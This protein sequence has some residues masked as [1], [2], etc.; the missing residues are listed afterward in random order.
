MSI[1]YA[2]RYIEVIVV[3]CELLFIQTHVICVYVSSLCNGFAAKREV[4]FCVKLAA[5]ARVIALNLLLF[6]AVWLAVCVSC[7]RYSHLEWCDL[8]LSICYAERYI[9]VVIVV[10][11]L[12]FA[13]THV[14]CV[15]VSSLCSSFAAK[16]EVVFC[17]KITADARDFIALDLLL[18]TAVWLAF[19]VSC[20][21]YSHCERCDLQLSICDIKVNIIIGACNTE[22]ILSKTHWICVY[23]CSL[24][25][26]FTTEDD[27][28]FSKVCS[29]RNCDIIAFNFLFFAAIVL[30]IFVS[31][32]INYDICLCDK[33]LSIC[34]GKC[35][36]EVIVIVRELILCQTHW[37]SV[38]VSSL[39]NC[40]A[41]ECEVAFSVERITDFY[42][43]S[44]DLLL[45]TAVLLRIFVSC[46]RYSHCE[47]CNLQLSICY[48]K[49]YIEVVVVICELVLSKTHWVSVHISSL[50]NCF[51]AE[52]EVVFC[53]KIIVD[54]YFVAF[55]LLLFTVVR[56]AVFVSGNRYGYL[57][58]CDLQFT[59]FKLNVFNI[60]VSAYVIA[61]T[62]RDSEFFSK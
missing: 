33:E 61:I 57:K 7:N 35:Y 24:C 15:Y 12:L 59:R 19:C 25:N 55:N 8:Q 60:I 41:T 9:E 47:R 23:I 2:E 21:R 1:C 14:I 28:V 46:N 52:L 56:L 48:G 17:V 10:C 16:R 62:I 43:V 54:L 49:C 3:V 18:F 40:L 51:T 58:R 27:V 37:I 4:V 30:N 34:Y 13:Q 31:G 53:V 32:Y 39:C 22:L 44:F 6:T 38:H 45:F 5:D 20:N 26:C 42:I 36:I 50:C 11:E 29:L